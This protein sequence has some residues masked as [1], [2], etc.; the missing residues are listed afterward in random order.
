MAICAIVAWFWV[1]HDSQDTQQWI[2]YDEYI[3]DNFFWAPGLGIC[4]G[5]YLRDDLIGE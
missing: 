3:T 5:S 2:W 4:I 1:I